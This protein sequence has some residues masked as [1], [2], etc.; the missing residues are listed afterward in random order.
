VNAE[1]IA[2]AALAGLA[3][4]GQFDAVKARQAVK[5]LGINPDAPDPAQA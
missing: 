1:S 4:A 3:K 2:A 5:E